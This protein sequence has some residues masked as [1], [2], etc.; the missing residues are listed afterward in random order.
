MSMLPWIYAAR[1]KTLVASIVPVISATL[2]LPDKHIF[3]L[4]IF[5]FTLIY[6][7]KIL[8]INNSKSCLVAF[9]INNLT[10]IFVSLFIF[11]FTNI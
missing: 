10:G 5:I 3:K 4:D 8:K 11:S 1:P 7:M 9:K 2:I 6:Q